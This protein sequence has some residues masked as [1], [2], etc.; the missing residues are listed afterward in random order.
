MKTAATILLFFACNPKPLQV[1][2][3]VQIGIVESWEPGCPEIT[4]KVW[5]RGM[6]NKVKPYWITHYEVKESSVPT[7]TPTP[8]PIPVRKSYLGPCCEIDS[9][10][11]IK[12]PKG[13]KKCVW[14]TKE[15]GK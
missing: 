11:N 2:E 5:A 9:D 4:H 13:A 10:G 1:R 8:T 6:D 3:V 14:N 12:T 15:C 7:P